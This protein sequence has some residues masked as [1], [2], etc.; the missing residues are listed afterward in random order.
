MEYHEEFQ[1]LLDHT[2]LFSQ[3][4]YY[5]LALP[6]IYRRYI[7]SEEDGGAEFVKDS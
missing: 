2:L 5:C 3:T 1:Q 6:Q 7:F 4:L